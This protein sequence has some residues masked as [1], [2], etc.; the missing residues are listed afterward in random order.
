MQ[1]FE[2]VSKTNIDKTPSSVYKMCPKTECIHTNGSEK[3][4]LMVVL[5]VNAAG[6]VHNHLTNNQGK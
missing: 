4:H 2:E 1:E 5:T 3:H 6:H